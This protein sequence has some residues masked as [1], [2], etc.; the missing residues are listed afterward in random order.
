MSCLLNIE[1]AVFHGKV[2]GATLSPGAVLKDDLGKYFLCLYK[3]IQLF[4]N[5]QL[6]SFEQYTNV[7]DL[8]PSFSMPRAFQ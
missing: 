6:P 2:G 5:L 1:T 4:I 7:S 3:G 8:L